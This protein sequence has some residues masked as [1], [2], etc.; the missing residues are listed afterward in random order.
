[1]RDSETGM[2]EAGLGPHET[3]PGRSRH[4]GGNETLA[5]NDP[6][7]V[8]E[9]TIRDLSVHQSMFRPNHLHGA[10]PRRISGSCAD[11]LVGN[12]PLECLA[13]DLTQWVCHR[14]EHPCR[15]L[16]RRDVLDRDDNSAGHG[17]ASRR[18]FSASVLRFSVTYTLA[19]SIKNGFHTSSGSTCCIW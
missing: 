10:A 2:D 5:V 9:G 3:G 17:R 6:H 8:G 16:V 12:R 18:S 13:T 19:V 14:G 15:S 7:A 11:R 1:P 4:L